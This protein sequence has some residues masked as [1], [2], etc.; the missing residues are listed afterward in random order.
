[1]YHSPNMK[2]GSKCSSGWFELKTKGKLPD[3]R[4]YHSAVVKDGWLFVFGGQD[5]KEGLFNEMWKL[6]LDNF[7]KYE[8]RE[9]DEHEL[10]TVT[11]D[12]SLEWQPVEQHGGHEAPG[13]L[14]H[15]KA[16]IHNQCMYVFGGI[17]ESG[18][19]NADVYQ[20]DM[21]SNKWS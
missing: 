12:R 8:E 2:S 13:K 5:I 11:R 9:L 17:K 1:M 3:K 7:I 6:N 10:D 19:N 15:H 4:S 16:C 21:N 20:F 14:A 18:E